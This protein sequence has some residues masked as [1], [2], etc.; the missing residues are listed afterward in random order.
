VRS[1]SIA[2]GVSRRLYFV[3]T[4]VCCRQSART[5]ILVRGWNTSHRLFGYLV[6]VVLSWRKQRQV[7]AMLLRSAT[8]DY[9]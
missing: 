9:R 6:V 3:L 1:E 5:M 7:G 2:S 8:Q 4:T